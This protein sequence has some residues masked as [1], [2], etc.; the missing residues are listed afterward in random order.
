[1]TRFRENHPRVKRVGVVCRNFG[2]MV[3]AAG[4]GGEGDCLYLL[5]V[6]VKRWEIDM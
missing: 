4:G 5:N 3:R 1:M 2:S 6:S